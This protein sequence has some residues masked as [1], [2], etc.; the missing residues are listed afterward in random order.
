[1]EIFEALM[2]LLS[3]DRYEVEYQF[4]DSSNKSG[5]KTRTNVLMG[6]PSVIFA[7][8]IDYTRHPRY[9]EIQRRFIITNPR[10]DYEKYQ[11]AVELIIEKNCSPDFVYQRKI[12]SDEEKYMAREIIL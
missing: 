9:Q 2:T 6:W 8:A 4:V 11:S 1:S 7:Q 10:M 3:H 12:V 5:L